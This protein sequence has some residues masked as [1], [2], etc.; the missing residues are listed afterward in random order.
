[1]RTWTAQTT[2]TGDPTAVLEALTH[3]DA[4][5]AWSPVPFE[6]ERLDGERLVAGT[7]ARVVGRL[8]GFG[9]AFDVE[10]HEAGDERLRL[11][12]DGPVGIDV[13]YHLERHDLGSSVQAEVSVRAKSGL[14]GRLLAQATDALLAGGALREAVGRIAR[15]I[16]DCPEYALAA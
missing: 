14:R 15:H 6:V 12:A 5:S 3:P 4:I 1:M 13:A 8:A 7:R 11:V 10:V 9:V 16:D 2:V